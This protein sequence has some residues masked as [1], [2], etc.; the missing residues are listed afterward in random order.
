[1]DRD[2]YGLT[3]Q[4]KRTWRIVWATLV[5]TSGLTVAQITLA[6]ALVHVLAKAMRLHWETHH[7][8]A[9]CQRQTEDHRHYSTD[10]DWLE[11]AR[12]WLEGK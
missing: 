5:G 2:E 7:D 1:M 6:D 9:K 12:K 11:V 10:A 4:H 8:H 3:E